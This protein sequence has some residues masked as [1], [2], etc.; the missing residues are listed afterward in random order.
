MRDCLCAPAYLRLPQRY[1]CNR[2]VR[3]LYTVRAQVE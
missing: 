3:G 1:L 2:A